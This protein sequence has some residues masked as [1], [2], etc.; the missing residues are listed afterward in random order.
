MKNFIKS[1]G[2]TFY[3]GDFYKKI[4]D[5]KGSNAIEFLLKFSV[6]LGIC[7]GIL[8]IVLFIAFSP[9]IKK[10]ISNLI[11]ENYPANLVVTIKDGKMTTGDGQPFFI[12]SS[13]QSSDT[14]GQQGNVIAILPDETAEVSVLSKYNTSLAVT[15]DGIV[16]QQNNGQEIRIIKYTGMSL[17]VDKN[18]ALK[19]VQ[20]L[21]FFSLL[22]FAIGI[23][24]FL[25]IFILIMTGIH[26]LWLF[27]V[28]LLIW[29]FL[30]LKKIRVSYMDSYR[31]GMY[32]IVPLLITEII[33][34]PVGF[35]GRSFTTAIILL[36]V[37]FVTHKW[38]K[39]V[40]VK[41]EP[42]NVSNEINKVC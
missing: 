8:C 17:T 42:E 39:T 16:G 6:F 3:S 37:L 41:I 20:F 27:F 18:L 21:F 33:A 13:E 24:P 31:I 25:I 19:S 40:I 22:F 14:A 36:I 7:F 23:V 28:A 34:I 15:S 38:E 2:F 10:Q 35:S 32:T 9:F 12:K 5:E 4:K 11:D 1:I 29:A 26:L 30:S